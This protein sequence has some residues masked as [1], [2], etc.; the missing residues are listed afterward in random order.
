MTA[1]TARTALPPSLDDIGLE[2]PRRKSKLPEVALG[3]VIVALCGLA[4]LWWYSTA[5]ERVDVLALREPIT[6]GQTLQVED[7]IKVSIATEDPIASMAE[8]EF[9]SIVGLVAVSDLPAGTLINPAMFA[10]F[11][12]MLDGSVVVGLDL[13]IGRTPAVTPIPGD[14]VAVVLVPASAAAGEQS[15][16]IIVESATVVETAVIGTQG[17]RFMALSMSEQDATE[18]SAAAAL[19]RV[20]L[21]RV[22]G[23]GN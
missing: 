20:S 1:T 5:A 17:R 7:L 14:T 21:I 22:P 15:G 12:P 6:Q 19:G 2:G 13:E 8:A 11:N 23:V 3:L 16:E 10:Q 18:V 4:S 9:P